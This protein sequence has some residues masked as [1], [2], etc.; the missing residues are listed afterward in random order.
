MLFL[1]FRFS[2][3]IKKEGKNILSILIA[4]F[5]SIYAAGSISNSLVFV[6][7]RI[8]KLLETLVFDFGGQRMRHRLQQ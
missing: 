2:F 4:S 3:D 7:L 6:I 5:K 8:L 1:N